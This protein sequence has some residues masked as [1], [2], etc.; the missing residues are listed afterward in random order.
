MGNFEEVRDKLTISQLKKLESAAKSKAAT[1][2]RITKNNFQDEELP[3]ELFLAR[4]KNKQNKK[5]L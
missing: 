3:H 1:T 5:S 2:L 4:K